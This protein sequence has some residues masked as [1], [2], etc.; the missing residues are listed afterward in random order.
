MSIIKT[1]LQGGFLI[2]LPILLFVMVMT[3]VITLV[4][5][6]ATPLVDLF[7]PGTFGDP[8]FPSLLAIFML[9]AVSF[10]IGLTMKLK[11]VATFGC[12]IEQKTVG[13]LPIYRLVK[14]LVDGLL[15]AE[16]KGTF[17][18]ALLDVGRGNRQFCYIVEQWTPMGT[19]ICRLFSDFFQLPQKITALGPF[20][21]QGQ[22]LLIG[23]CRLV[24]ARGL[25]G[26]VGSRC[27]LRSRSL[28]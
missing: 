12:W 22:R 17:K 5:G 16:E 20:A 21:N 23:G 27:P 3:E 14:N 13:K 2:L 18:P 10:L 1:I 8:R 25:C 28:R 26:S 9:L 24:E 11:I 19:E 15:G 7:P 4:I 6:L